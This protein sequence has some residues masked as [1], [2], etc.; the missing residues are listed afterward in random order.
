[1]ICPNQAFRRSCSTSD[2]AFRPE[3]NRNGIAPGLIR[4][5]EK[6]LPVL[7]DGSP[8][9]RRFPS[10]SSGRQYNCHPSDGLLD[11]VG[12]IF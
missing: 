1:M 6:G 12:G 8:S 4:R 9:N 10:G 7:S 11:A 2:S 5:A 3:E